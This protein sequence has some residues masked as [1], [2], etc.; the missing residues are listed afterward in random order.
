MVWFGLP[1]GNQ[2]LG[3]LVTAK[4]TD[5]DLATGCLLCIAHSNGVEEDGEWGTEE[6]RHDSHKGPL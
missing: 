6:E 5:K 1:C 3:H 4:V 2:I